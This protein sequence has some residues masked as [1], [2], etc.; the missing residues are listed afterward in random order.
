METD[1]FKVEEEEEITETTPL[2]SLPKAK[3]K[4][5]IALT[6]ESNQASETSSASEGEDTDSE[7]EVEEK[8]K[9]ARKLIEEESRAVGKVNLAVWKLYLSLNGGILFWTFFIIAFIGTKI[10]D[11]AQSLWLSHWSGSYSSSTTGQTGQHSV[12]YYLILYAVLSFVGV[13]V[14]TSQWF[15]LYSGSLRASNRIFEMLLHSIL[16]APLRFFD[17][18]ALGRLLNR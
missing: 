18:I 12:N 10:A 14:S 5:L 3:N 2:K 1:R 17:T 9:P 6:T 16:R 8:E 11:V 13:I 4:T 7:D 15:V